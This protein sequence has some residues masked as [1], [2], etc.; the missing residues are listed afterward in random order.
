MPIYDPCK[1]V[2]LVDFA[3]QT[4]YLSIQTSLFYHIHMH[5]I[6][7]IFHCIPSYLNFPPHVVY[8]I[9]WEGWPYS[10]FVKVQLRLLEGLHSSHSI[11]TCGGRSMN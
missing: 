3:K 10:L 7:K 2:P 11:F 8:H 9:K 4:Q 5:N 6:L 1:D